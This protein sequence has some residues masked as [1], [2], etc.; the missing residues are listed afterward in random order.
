M[1]AAGQPAA[2]RMSKSTKR[3]AATPQI[4]G[5]VVASTGEHV[6]AREGRGY[7]ESFV[8]RRCVGWFPPTQGG[9]ALAVI[10]RTLRA[11][12]RDAPTTAHR[13]LALDAAA[14]PEAGYEY[15]ARAA[16]ALSALELKRAAAQAAGRLDGARAKIADRDADIARLRARL[17]DADEELGEW[18]LGN[19]RV[20]N[21][22][23]WTEAFEAR[24]GARD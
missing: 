14:V 23:Q 4:F 6:R 1:N 19:L 21:W 13:S 24:R 18:R 3:T 2:T 5:D 17:A 7:N 16:P 12:L 20:S 9:G 15:M 10:N 22:K 11:R 8:H